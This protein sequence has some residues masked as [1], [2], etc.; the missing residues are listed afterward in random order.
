MKAPNQALFGIS[1]RL[2]FK[3]ESKNLYKDCTK[4]QYNATVPLCGLDF[5]HLLP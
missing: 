2:H 1:S 3:V 5:I 4:K